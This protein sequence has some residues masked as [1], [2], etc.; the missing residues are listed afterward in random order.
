MYCLLALASSYRISIQE[1]I[2]KERRSPSI[3]G[4]SPLTGGGPPFL[5]LYTGTITAKPRCGLTCCLLDHVLVFFDAE[6]Y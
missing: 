6:A 1:D 5:L 4:L 3:D 2:N